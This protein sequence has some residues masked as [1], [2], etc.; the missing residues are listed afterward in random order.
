MK[1]KDDDGMYN[2]KEGEQCAKRYTLNVSK[3]MQKKADQTKLGSLQ[4]S[5]KSNNL[6]MEMS[7]AAYE[8][9]KRNIEI[10][11]E[12]GLKQAVEIASININNDDRTEQQGLNTDSLITIDIAD[13]QKFIVLSLYHTKSKIMVNGKGVQIFNDNVL[14]LI[15]DNINQNEMEIKA[16]ND[17]IYKGINCSKSKINLNETVSKNDCTKENIKSDKNINIKK[18][19]NVDSKDNEADKKANSYVLSINRKNS[20][21][22]TNDNDKNTTTSID[23]LE[24]ENV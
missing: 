13:Q 16:I 20:L 7:T 19:Q 11:L 21:T 14:P 18:M 9:V 3:A 24:M 5:Y 8:L 1:D 4:V 15:I 10:L 22:E 12:E 23:T 2:K 6:V 17:D